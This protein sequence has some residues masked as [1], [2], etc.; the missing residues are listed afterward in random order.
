MHKLQ[1]DYRMEIDVLILTT[2]E[3]EERPLRD[4]D[5]LVSLYR[6]PKGLNLHI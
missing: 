1:G 4:M 5:Q 2:K 3:F 6:A